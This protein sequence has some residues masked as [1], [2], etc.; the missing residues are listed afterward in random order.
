MSMPTRESRLYA[1]AALMIAGALLIIIGV[2]R[3]ELLVSSIVFALGL[4]FA[5]AA[6]GRE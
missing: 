4:L 1:G 3:R 5:V 6:F 2:D